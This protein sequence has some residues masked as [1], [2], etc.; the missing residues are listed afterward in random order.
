[1]TSSASIEKFLPRSLIEAERELARID[2]EYL[3]KR[4]RDFA[5]SA[6]PLIQPGV[7]LIEGLAFDAIT[8]HLQAVADGAVEKLLINVPPGNAK[9]SLVSVLFPC[10][11]WSRRPET[12]VMCASHGQNLALRDSVRRRDYVI[13]S[14]WYQARWGDRV[15]LLESQQTKS[16]FLNTAGG[17]MF[18]TSIGG[19]VLGRRAEVMVLDDPHKVQEAESE[20]E[21]ANV[22]QWLNLEWSTRRNRNAPISAEVCVMQRLHEADAAGIFLKQGGWTHLCL[23]MYFEAARRCVTSTGWTDPR[24]NERD[25]LDVALNTDK[26]REDLEK[27]LGPYGLAGQFQ[28]RPV[29]LGGGIIKAA[30]IKRWQKSETQPGHMT[31]MDGRYTFDPWRTLRFATVDL[32]MTER[33][34]GAK[35]IHDPDY[36]VMAAWVALS[37]PQGSALALLDLVRLRMEGPDTLE[38]LVLLH[39]RWR[40]ALIGVEDVSEKMWF[41]L[42][43][44]RGLP[45]R[46]ISTR[47]SDDA[48]YVIDRDKV[49]RAIAVTPMMAA[50]L[51]HVPEYAPWLEEYIHELTVFPLAAHDDMVDATVYGCAIAAKYKGEQ[52]QRDEQ[53]GN[54]R[55][56]EDSRRDMDAPP[57]PLDG[58]FAARPPGV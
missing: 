57:N 5:R 45:V 38:R 20:V 16:E 8:A 7:T 42:A 2:R 51:F 13:A 9:S 44:R 40:F 3:P 32:A 52:T 34:A 29:P 19:D 30:W 22:A 21:R 36:T 18:S 11:L 25:V 27:R 1:M 28:Q 24:A 58:F 31:V 17:F 48:L 12:Q 6:W 35:K 37:T 14:P 46:E 50:G 23:P 49:S 15:K 41:Q 26:A 10:W 53:D 47:K 56:A 54:G 55:A 43:R 33:E 4:F 39:K